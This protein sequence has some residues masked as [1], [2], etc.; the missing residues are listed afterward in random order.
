[1]LKF[2]NFYQNR[3]RQNTKKV[4]DYQKHLYFWRILNDASMPKVKIPTVRFTLSQ[5]RDGGETAYIQMYF[6]Y[7]GKRLKYSTGEKVIPDGWDFKKQRA[8]TTRKFPHGVDTNVAL[9][10]LAI[11][12]MRIFRDTN[13]GNIEPHE[14]SKKL[15][16]M[17]GYALESE[18]VATPTLLEFSEAFTNKYARD[19]PKN[20]STWKTLFLTIKQ[21]NGY[22]A[23]KGVRLEFSEINNVFFSDLVVWL[24]AP[25]REYSRNYVA[26]VIKRLKMFMQKAFEAG[27][28]DNRAY[29]GFKF[30]EIGSDEI[31]LSFE[32]L[33][34]L[35]K[36]DFTTNQRLDRVRDIFLIGCFTGQRYSDYNRIRPEH[37]IEEGGLKIISILTKKTGAK[38][39]I[40][41]YPILDRLLRKYDFDLPT[42]SLT[43]F[44]EDIKE[45]CRLAGFTDTILIKENRAGAE[46]EREVSRYTM[47]TTHTARRSFATN[48]ILAKIPIH[49]VM[50][51]LGHKTE[52]E[53]RKYARISESQA[54]KGFSLEME[55]LKNSPGAAYLFQ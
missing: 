3:T 1:M 39:K 44:N 54:A 46:K 14:F 51:I 53:T 4:S 15:D 41:L 10:R 30:T 35:S 5:R 7:A 22:A 28:H 27:L 36:M 6:H 23:D 34:V 42:K 32:D 21:L 2:D 52:A 43:N 12:T 31:A 47:I 20:R 45:V 9:D 55:V 18:P 24:Y 38:V 19:F 33:Q 17:M 16:V 48:F 50:A 49:L 37:I 13:L 8:L 40:P 25:P 29:I 11:H 26:F